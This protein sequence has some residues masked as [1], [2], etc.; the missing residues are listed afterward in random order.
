MQVRS[1]FVSGLEHGEGQASRGD[2][3]VLGEA[4]KTDKQK[5]YLSIISGFHAKISAFSNFLPKKVG[6][7]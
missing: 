5:K 4:F 7:H 3:K 1:S 6:A 2:G